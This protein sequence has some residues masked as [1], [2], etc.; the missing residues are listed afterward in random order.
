MIAL[1]RRLPAALLAPLAPPGLE[2]RDHARRAQLVAR[3]RAEYDE[4]P[5][6]RLTVPQAQR[7]FGLRADVCV[8]VLTALTAEC[9]LCLGSDGRYSARANSA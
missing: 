8:R 3:V 4:M 9:L 6:L 2:R 7:L 1:S 5:C